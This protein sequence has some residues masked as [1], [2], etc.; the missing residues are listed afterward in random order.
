MI[1]S[2]S[3]YKKHEFSVQNSR[4]HNLPGFLFG[5]SNPISSSH[6][7]SSPP[8]LNSD[9]CIVY[10][11]PNSGNRLD[12]IRARALSVAIKLEI[13]AC[14]FDF[15]A[16]GAADGDYVILAILQNINLIILMMQSNCILD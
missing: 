13:A 5:A 4:G 14:G 9:V 11:H 10:M 8:K 6:I 12:L 1:G 3:T 16:C 7:F 2:N 15:S